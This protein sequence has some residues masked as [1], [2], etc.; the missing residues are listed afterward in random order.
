MRFTP[1]SLL[2][3]LLWFGAGGGQSSEPFLVHKFHYS[4]FQGTWAILSPD[5][6]YLYSINDP[7]PGQIKRIEWKTGSA[8]RAFDFSHV[9]CR[10]R[11]GRARE[12]HINWLGFPPNMEVV[13]LVYCSSL[14]VATLPS[15]E[16]TEIMADSTEEYGIVPVL[17]QDGK[18][19]AVVSGSHDRRADS[20]W[21]LTLYTTKS[22]LP[23]AQQAVPSNTLTFT[24]S[25]TQLAV[26]KFVKGNENTPDFCG[27]TF[28]K[29]PTLQTARTIEF[30]T[31]LE[32]CPLL[33]PLYFVSGSS[34]MILH[35]Q[36]VFGKIDLWDI[37][38]G[39]LVKTIKDDRPI[40][41]ATSSPDGLWIFGSV[42]IKRYR[43]RQDFKVWNTV[44]GKPVYESEICRHC[45][46]ATPRDD[47]PPFGN[48]S[49]DGKY[50][51]VTSSTGIDIYS[52]RGQ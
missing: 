34:E 19:L 18:W 5:N 39:E 13:F 23:V 46:G 43:V 41:D 4:D 33:I 12:G 8:E 47:F 11:D 29:I 16:L 2:I 17:S 14:Y 52:V 44:T 37:T 24:L 49:H 20:D 31:S 42:W 36:F 35:N 48:F 27:L 6:E 38:T 28:L 7:N 22:L 30:Q 9:P 32:S 1:I 40:R 10:L 3:I 21:V 25:G 50:L 51:V 45:S 15:W 26:Q